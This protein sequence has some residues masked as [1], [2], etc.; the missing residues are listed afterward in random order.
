MGRLGN[1]NHFP[2]AEDHLGKSQH[3][4]MDH[5]QFL[6]KS[7]SVRSCGS[8]PGGQYCTCL[9]S[10]NIIIRIPIWNSHAAPPP[11]EEQRPP[12]P[13]PL[14]CPL[15][16]PR[17]LCSHTSLMYILYAAASSYPATTTPNWYY[18]RTIKFPLF[19]H[20]PFHELLVVINVWG[21]STR[22]AAAI[23]CYFICEWP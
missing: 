16:C 3:Q 11:H 8:A 1:F 13:L 9:I 18:C 10:S 2:S 15:S 23:R 21:Y 7:I 6:H 14:T 20:H 22:G 4:L 17:V 12:P 5:W 19:I